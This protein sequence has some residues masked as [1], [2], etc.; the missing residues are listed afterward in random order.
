VGD[1]ENRVLVTT[2]RVL[3]TTNRVLVTTNRVLVTTDRVLVTKTIHWCSRVAHGVCDDEGSTSHT[4][5]MTGGRIWVITSENRW[6]E[7]VRKPLLLDVWRDER[8]DLRQRGER[9]GRLVRTA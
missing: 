4:P 1:L 3:V 2:N 5:A 9:L 7:N 8:L 6:R